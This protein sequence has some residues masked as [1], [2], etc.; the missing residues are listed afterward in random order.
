MLDRELFRI[1]YKRRNN[2]MRRIQQPL[3]ITFIL[4]G[5]LFAGCD[6]VGEKG[7][8]TLITKSHDVTDFTSVSAGDGFK[9]KITKSD[10]YTIEITSDDNIMEFVN[11]EKN[12]NQ[13][14]IDMDPGKIYSM[15]TLKA[16]IGLPRLTGTTLS[17]GSQADLSGFSSGN[18][19]SAVLSGGSELNGDL[20]A[21][22]VDLDLSG[23]SK[24]MLSGY[25]KDLTI[26]GS[27][28]SS[29]DL[30]ELPAED[31]SITLSGG[32]SATIRVSGTLNVDLSSGS[33]LYYS[34]NPTLDNVTVSGGS[35]VEEK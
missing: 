33:K 19:F 23:G 27:G 1:I 10:T 12:G 22:D 6:I 3:I 28:A 15:V 32:S 20:G 9:V 7:S 8:G 35:V 29:L 11:V 4:T 24:A 31:G 21:G 5:L 13:L 34:G 16:T 30:E 2:M 25:A 26:S 17:G 18:N 14:I